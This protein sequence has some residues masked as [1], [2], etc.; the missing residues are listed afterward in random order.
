MEA[1]TELHLHQCLKI[2]EAVFGVHRYWQLMLLLLAQLCPSMRLLDLIGDIA[3][4]VQLAWLQATVRA[5]AT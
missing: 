2:L 1:P 5:T 3:D 4:I